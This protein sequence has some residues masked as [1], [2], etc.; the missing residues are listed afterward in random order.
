MWKKYR[1]F[2]DPYKG[3]KILTQIAN[4]LPYISEYYYSTRK[5]IETQ[6]CSASTFRNEECSDTF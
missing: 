6:Y 3:V 2:K 5:I 4:L 1:E